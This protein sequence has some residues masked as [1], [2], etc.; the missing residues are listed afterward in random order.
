MRQAWYCLL[1]VAFRAFSQQPPAQ[2]E[3]VIVTGTYDPIPLQESDRAVQVENISPGRALLSN[4]IVDFL[5][6][7]S[8]VDLQ[9]RAPNNIQ[10]D[11]SIRGTNFGQTLILLNG[12]RINDAQSGHHDMDLPLPL[13][14]ISQVEIL[15]G[16]G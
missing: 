4:S 10:S 9:Q 2:H 13:E 14:S 6:L 16:S 5:Q 1:L 12:L 7:D 11:I 8:S 3:T 15:K